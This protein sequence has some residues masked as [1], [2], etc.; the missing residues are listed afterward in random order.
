V[1]EVSG[2]RLGSARRLDPSDPF[3]E[4]AG[5]DIGWWLRARSAADGLALA[6]G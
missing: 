2:W 1:R 4:P 5:P 6:S 3:P